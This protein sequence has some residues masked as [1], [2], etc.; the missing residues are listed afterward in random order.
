MATKKNINY[1]NL[2]D[3]LYNR[4]DETLG[5]L[6][7]VRSDIAAGGITQKEL[8]DRLTEIYYKLSGT[9]DNCDMETEGA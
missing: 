8:N 6:W 1:S 3:V 5:S 2:Y 9:V 4:V 7:D